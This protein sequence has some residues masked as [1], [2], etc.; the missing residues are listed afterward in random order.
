MSDNKERLYE[1]LQW[2]LENPEEK[3]PIAARIRQESR[4]VRR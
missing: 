3:M 2:L 4:G 1:A